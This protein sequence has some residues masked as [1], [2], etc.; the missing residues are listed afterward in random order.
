MGSTTNLKENKTL[1]IPCDCKS[2]VLIIEYDH[3][4]ESAD[5]AIYEN[6]QS[7]KHKLSIWQRIRYAVRCL[8][9]G[10]PYG[11]QIMMNKK[12]LKELRSFLASLTL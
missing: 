5:V 11:D 12:Q 3:N 2:E 10:R 1:F 8:V 9:N 6:I 4:I 7:F